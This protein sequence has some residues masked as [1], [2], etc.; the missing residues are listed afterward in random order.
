MDED[1]SRW[2]YLEDHCKDVNY[3]NLENHSQRA[4]Q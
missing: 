1:K 2:K 4:Q 3:E